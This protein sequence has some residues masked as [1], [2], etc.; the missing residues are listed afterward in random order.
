MDQ[1][2]VWDRDLFGPGTETNWDGGTTVWDLIPA[3]LNY[4]V[5]FSWQSVSRSISWLNPGRTIRW[6]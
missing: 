4:A 5:M 6:K 3:V 2:T 1:R